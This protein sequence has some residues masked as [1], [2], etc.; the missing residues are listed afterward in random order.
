M[1][2]D[3]HSHKHTSWYVVLQNLN[4][5]EWLKHYVKSVYRGHCWQYLCCGHY[6][7]SQWPT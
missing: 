4:G 7:W 1:E 3:R 2:T 6:C 5:E